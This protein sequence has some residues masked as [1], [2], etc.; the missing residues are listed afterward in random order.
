MVRKPLPF[1]EIGEAEVR[2]DLA[3]RYWHGLRVD[4]SLLPNRKALDHAAF[5][6]LIDGTVWINVESADPNNWEIN[7]LFLQPE[8]S[9]RPEKGMPLLRDV[10][11][12]D[13]R[14]TRF[15]ASP[16]FQLLDVHNPEIRI[17]QLMLPLADNGIHVD[18]ILL[19]QSARDA[20]MA[21]EA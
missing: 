6:F 10:L 19:I 8:R 11:L 18:T 9:C 17:H 4:H 7:K 5:R 20:E 1:S 13:C 14:T 12:S 2:I 21:L 15:T 16:L 3:Y